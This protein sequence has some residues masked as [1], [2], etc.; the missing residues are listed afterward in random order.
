MVAEHGR[1]MEA[2]ATAITPTNGPQLSRSSS[3]HGR[4]LPDDC[5]LIRAAD[6]L[7]AG[8]RR[9]DPSVRAVWF[10]EG[11]IEKPRAWPEQLTDPPYAADPSRTAVHTTSLSSLSV[12]QISTDELRS[13]VA[14]QAWFHT[15]DLG[16]GIV[17]PGRDESPRKLRWIDLPERLAGK[18]VLDVG[19]WDGFFSFEA[20]RRGAARVLALDSV[21]WQEPAWGPRGWGT[22]AGFELARRALGSQV[23]DLTIDFDEI[24]PATV[25]Q[26]DVVL[27][28][29]VLYHMKNPW[30]I[31]EQMRS[32]C[33]ELLI[34]ET[35]V[36][37]LDLPRAAMAI[38]PENELAADESNW[39]GPNLRALSGMLK[40]SGFSSVDVVHLDGRS[41]RY[42]RSIYRL[43]NKPR[44]RAQQ[45]RCVVHARP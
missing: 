2:S 20:E 37:L 40:A 28:L 23:E 1:L 12:P 30:Q 11:E 41:Y 32:V 7:Q 34:L 27:F 38:Y 18:T 13:Q 39:C 22:K 24:S 8:G 31:L 25:G 10:I 15:I 44:F 21:A 4:K 5:Q 45:G 33:R 29:G 6:P 42:A 19:A 36:D 16:N 3:I 17:T 26:F 43:V 14:A 35:H 9:F